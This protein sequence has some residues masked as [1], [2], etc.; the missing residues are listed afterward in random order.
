MSHEIVLSVKLIPVQQEDEIYNMLQDK[1]L[2]R[3]IEAEIES[4]IA[5][6][7]GT[8]RPKLKSESPK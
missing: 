5:A 6:I 4:T 3:D 2:R 8:G 1:G 7:M